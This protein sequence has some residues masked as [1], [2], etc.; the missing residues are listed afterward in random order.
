MQPTIIDYDEVRKSVD[1]LHALC[2]SIVK[3]YLSR[4]G[5]TVDEFDDKFQEIKDKSGELIKSLG[6]EPYF[7]GFI[8]VSHMMSELQ[9]GFD[10]IGVATLTELLDDEYLQKVNPDEQLQH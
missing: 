5:I 1:I 7:Y 10:S 8:V 2:G 3:S 9:H 6:L 4:L